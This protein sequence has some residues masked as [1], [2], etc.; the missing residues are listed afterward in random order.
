MSQ[1][2]ALVGVGR[3]EGDDSKYSVTGDR[4][5]TIDMY[6][7][8]TYAR[9]EGDSEDDGGSNGKSSREPSGVR[10]SR[11]CYDDDGGMDWIY[12]FFSFLIYLL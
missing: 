2:D 7:T 5:G 8:S 11:S 10:V 1:K 6:I 9:G 4:W 12:L 3:R